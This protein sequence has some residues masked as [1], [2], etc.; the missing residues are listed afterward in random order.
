MITQLTT[1]ESAVTD[2]RWPEVA[3][4]H[5]RDPDEAHL[6][7]AEARRQGTVALGPFG[8]EALGYALVRTVL[9][10]PRF[11]TAKGLGLGIQGISSG[12]LWDRATQSILSLDGAAH[13]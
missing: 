1:G 10:D 7:I 12:P 13:H 4:Q 2:G 9:R 8:P 3:Y 5:L 11:A 6:V